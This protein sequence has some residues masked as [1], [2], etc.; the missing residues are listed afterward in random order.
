MKR[1]TK[2][3]PILVIITFYSCAE[4][5]SAPFVPQITNFWHNENN[6]DHTFILSTED[7]GLIKGTLT[8]TEDYPDSNFFG[9][10]L[11]GTFNSRDIDFTV[12]RPTGNF[13]YYGKITSENRMELNSS[14]GK[15]IIV[16]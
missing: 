7:E 15:I 14:A 4:E 1:Y 6:E 9:S 11:S 2:A 16:K 5:E 8:G 3:L 12:Q 13:R 10:D